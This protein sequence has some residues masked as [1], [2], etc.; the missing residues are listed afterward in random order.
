MPQTS[1]SAPDRDDSGVATDKP[2]GGDGNG[3]GQC[4]GTTI[5][6]TSGTLSGAPAQ[7]VTNRLRYLTLSGVFRIE[8][9]TVPTIDG[10]AITSDPGRDGEY[11]VGDDI[12][13]AVAF[14]EAVQVTGTPQFVIKLNAQRKADYVASESTA[15]EL[16]FSY[17]VTSTDFDLDGVSA[18][19][20][21][22]K[23]NGGSIT[24]AVGDGDAVLASPKL[25]DQ[26]S[27][28][29]HSVRPTATGASV[30]SIPAAGTSYATGETIRIA[31]T[32][33]RDVK[34]VTAAGTPTFKIT[35][36]DEKPVYAEY[37][38]VVGDNTVHFDYIVE[39]DAYDDD[40]FVTHSYAI[41]WNGG[42]I[43][44]KEVHD[45]LASDLPA[46][47]TSTAMPRQDNHQVNANRPV[48]NQVSITSTP[49][50][51]T[52]TY[53]A[54]GTIAV[55]VAFS[56]A[57]HVDISG[58]TPRL[59]MQFQ[60]AGEVAGQ[61][62]Y[63]EYASGSGT[64]ALVFHYD[65]RVGDMDDDG[66]ASGADALELNGGTIRDSDGTDAFLAHAAPTGLSSHKVD[67]SLNGEVI[68]SVNLASVAE[69]ANSTSVTVTATLDAAARTTATTVTVSVG[70]V[71]DGATAG[72]DYATVNDFILTIAAGQTLGTAT[73]TLTP[74]DDLLGEGDETLTVA[75]TTAAE[76]IT[77][78]PTEVTI[79]DDDAVSTVVTLS[80]SPLSVDENASGTS[81]TVT[82]TLD[83]AA[84]SAATA[85]TV[86]VGAVGDGATAGTDYATVS[87]FTLTITA[88][89]TLGTATFTLTPTD[90]L[91]GEGDETLTMAG[92]T[93][94]KLTV[95]L[96]R[97]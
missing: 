70:A 30:V 19:L 89:Q 54:D 50:A 10:V 73:F 65:V 53:G 4:T 75:G 71:R 35:L 94:A 24:N 45:G 82:A 46:I 1:P 21:A 69:D 67:G 8:D 93:A 90:D 81:V 28:K 64:N 33:D 15:T 44:R 36:D 56:K 61:D 63:L 49:T 37:S 25:E 40:G 86:S 85:V 34:V 52:D 47:V 20:N 60:S 87:D 26:S 27:H 51:S 95:T 72:T 91:L 7:D 23:L 6:T 16:V 2:L 62:R 96:R 17:Q 48:I 79:T 9:F 76:N 57:V 3:G 41:E 22:L 84:R 80:V 32:F 29:V 88:G 31:V 66:I 39:S 12:K 92:T 38:E 5:N 14:S 58:G 74:T 78:T 68:L 83:A 59:S 77:V 11:T 55:R 42:F 18:P 13:I 43:T 97:N